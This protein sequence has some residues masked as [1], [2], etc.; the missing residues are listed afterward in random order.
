MSGGTGSG[1]D[2]RK[3]QRVFI[4]LWP[5]STVRGRLGEVAGDLAHRA[6]RARPVAP[7]NFHLTL[8][9]IGALDADRATEL[10]RRLDRLRS[11][12]FEW[13]LDHVGHFDRARVLW[14]S[15]PESVSLL[16]LAA[17]VRSELDALGIAYDSKPFSPHVTLLRNV[18]RWPGQTLPIEPPI[19][20][21]CERATLVRSEQ[22]ANGVTYMPD[23]AQ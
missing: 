12:A 16:A 22:G 14:A 23:I 1:A 11:S 7:A 2:A 8:A 19:V 18:V 21:P 9:F 17:T 15:G 5:T 4:A 6:T 20:W 10:A 13:E 3:Q